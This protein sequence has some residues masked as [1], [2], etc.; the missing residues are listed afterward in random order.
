MKT[1]GEVRHH[2]GC[3]DFPNFVI[4]KIR[5]IDISNVVDCQIGHETNRRAGR[6]AVVACITL[7][8]SAC[9]GRDDSVRVYLAD[10]KVD[11]ICNIEIAR[12]VHRHGRWIN[13][14]GRRRAIVTGELGN[15]VAG[16]RIDGAIH[17][18]PAHY[19]IA[20]VGDIQ[21]PLRVQR[22]ARGEV[23]LRVGRRAS[24]AA[25]SR[26]ARARVG[27]DN[28][29]RVHFSNP[30]V[31]FI[32]DIEISLSVQRNRDR[33]LAMEPVFA[34]PPSSSRGVPARVLIR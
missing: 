29:G 12:A 7:F 19:V 14:S 13:L 22:N 27:A 26:N 30:I 28:S 2:A 34:R 3:I 16:H 8:S 25:I 33:C 23:E 4:V 10:T 18:Y 17:C 32:G 24:V 1:S 15:S 21:V 31:G 20:F 11:A 9:D 5:Q 6:R